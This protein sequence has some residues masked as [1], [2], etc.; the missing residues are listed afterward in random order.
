MLPKGICYIERSSG[1]KY[2][3]ISKNKI[4]PNNIYILIDKTNPYNSFKEAISIFLEKRQEGY[5]RGGLLHSDLDVIKDNGL[6]EGIYISIKYNK[7]LT[8][9][10]KYFVI[11]EYIDSG[12]YKSH[13]FKFTDSTYNSVLEEAKF[14]A[15][16]YQLDY[17][18]RRRILPE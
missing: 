13:H 6:P 8:A 10:Y 4:T 17:N 16:F 12:R 2:F 11:R 7:D 9:E 1:I 18:D 15:E 5:D 3:V 14:Y